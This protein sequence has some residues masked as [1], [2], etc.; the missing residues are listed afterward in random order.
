VED[1][2]KTVFSVLVLGFPLSRAEHRPRGR[3]KRVG[4]LSEASSDTLGPVDDAQEKAGHGRF[5]LIPF[6]FT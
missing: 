1:G 5:L 2:L 4:C 3:K 6:S